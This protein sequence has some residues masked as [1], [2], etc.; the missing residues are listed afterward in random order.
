V[1]RIFRRRQDEP[2]PEAETRAIA[3]GPAEEVVHARRR[4]PPR[5]WPWLIALLVVVA[6]A[7]AAA[8]FLTRDDDGGGPTETAA[9]SV[10]DVV[11]LQAQP[12]SSRLVAAG[13][14]PQLAQ[15]ESERPTGVVVRQRPAAGT[16]L[17]RGGTVTLVVSRG[18]A[19]VEVPDVLGLSLSRAFSRL[20]T[21]GL[22]PRA[23]RVFSSKPRGRV[24]R[25]QPAAGAQVERERVVLLTVSRGPARVP[26]PDLIGQRRADAVRSLESAGLQANVVTVAASEPAGTV[27]AQNPA[28]GTRIVRGSPVRV[29]VSRGSAATTTRPTTTRPPTTTAPTPTR[30]GTASSV[31]TVPDV[32]GLDALT[33]ERR[34]RQA[35]FVASSAPRATQDPAEDGIV[36]EQRPP[37]GSSARAGAQ[38]TITVGMLTPLSRASR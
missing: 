25:Q 23:R 38:V 22:Q 24:L 28:G 32:V 19:K 34:L 13:F 30:T 15:V 2:S 3:R 10:P 27:V 21:A 8:Y 14:R 18:P 9:T 6:A 26:V 16:E 35:G 11:G 7:I 20:E 12:A 5:I 1:R 36:L 37:G 33:A 17:E 29:N 31:A 4:R